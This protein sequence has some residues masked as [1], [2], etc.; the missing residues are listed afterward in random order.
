MSEKIQEFLEVPQEFIQEGN[1]VCHP[2]LALIPPPS[3]FI[4]LQFLVRC[5]KPSRKGFCTMLLV[6]PDHPLISNLDA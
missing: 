4:L 2:A 1:Q 3:Y 6:V 5:T